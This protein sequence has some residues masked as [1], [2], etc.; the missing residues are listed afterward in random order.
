MIYEKAR[1][2]ARFINE[3]DYA[4]VLEEAETSGENLQNA[5]TEFEEF[6]TNVMNIVKF[7]TKNGDVIEKSKGCGGCCSKR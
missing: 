2:L 1:E 7:N 6:V 3:S 4:K 5:K